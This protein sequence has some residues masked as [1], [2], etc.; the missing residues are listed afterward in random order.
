MAV[1]IDLGMHI[2][3]DTA[4]YLARGYRVVA[5]EANPVLVRQCEQRF[6]TEL[7]SG[8]LS[9]VNGAISETAGTAA[10]FIAA[11]NAEWS[12][13]EKWRVTQTGGH[14]EVA[15]DTYTLSDIIARSG[16]PEFIKCDIEGADGVFCRQLIGLAA[17]PRYVSVE[18]SSLDWI[19]CLVAAGYKQ[20]QLVNQAALR[21]RPPSITF[22]RDGR[23]QNW[24]FGSYASGP[25]GEDLPNNWISFQEVARR[26]LDFQRLKAEAADMVL[27]NWFDVHARY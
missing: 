21:R 14:K 24:T 27:D 23:A 19:A 16:D 5:M 20:F 7:A 25:F 15:V 9:I 18:A 10:F 11:A 12:S 22:H 26:W 13:L 8:A 2:G 1:V 3:D 17:K 6:A 4:Y